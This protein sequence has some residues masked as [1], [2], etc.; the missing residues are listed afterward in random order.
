MAQISQWLKWGHD[1]LKRAGTPESGK[2]LVFSPPFCWKVE[3]IHWIVLLNPWRRWRLI[4]KHKK[5]ST[6]P[7]QHQISS[8]TVVSRSPELPDLHAHDTDTSSSSRPSSDRS[9]AILR[10]W[11][12][13]EPNSV[14]PWSSCGVPAHTPRPNQ[15]R[16]GS[17][18]HSQCSTAFFI[19][20][21]N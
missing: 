7:N 5:T 15:S 2:H 11:R 17:S 10:W 19:V 9:A 3:W 12:R 1:H 16:A 4:L 21:D 14:Q 6:A 13:L 20:R 18:C 8:A